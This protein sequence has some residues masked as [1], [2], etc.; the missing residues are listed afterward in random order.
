[1]YTYIIYSSGSS[2]KK[3]KQV[4]YCDPVESR[5]KSALATPTEKI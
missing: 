4:I 5:A 3:K 1:M 2:H